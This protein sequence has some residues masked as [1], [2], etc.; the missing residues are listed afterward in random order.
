[1]NRTP[2]VAQFQMHRPTNQKN[3]YGIF[4]GGLS[5]G[6]EVGVRGEYKLLINI[7]T[8]FAPLTSSGK[9]PDLLPMRDAILKTCRKS[10]SSAKKAH[11]R[12]PGPDGK[13]AK[14][15]AISEIA[16]EV[17]E[18]AYNHAS[19][20]VGMA[21]ARQVMYAARDLIIKRTGNAQPWSNSNYFTQDLLAAY[22]NQHKLHDKWD[23]LYDDRGH[24]EEPHT[25]ARLGIGTLAVR[26]YV[27]GWPKSLPNGQS[28]AV[29]L[30][31][32]FPTVGPQSRYCFAL[33]VEKEGFDE[34]FRRVQLA[35][36]F[37]VG[38]FSTKG[39][40]VTAARQ[41]VDKL[42]AKNVTVLVLHDFDAYGFSI[43]HSLKTDNDRYTYKNKPRV[44]GLRLEDVIELGL[45]RTPEQM[46]YTKN[47]G[48]TP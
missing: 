34:L 31:H 35:E 36:R 21:S 8:P 39:M 2:V 48:V 18:E 13:P 41:L 28:D 4:G 27:N 45:D 20:G 40:S 24:F 23:V 15:K 33:F 42:S 32:L 25:G 47:R 14:N 37:D 26:R 5:H 9:D 11:K 44:K 12:M 43:L 29:E 10:V 6:F 30:N 1:M 17:M 19:A 38:I 3:K 16:F 22:I 46:V 7:L